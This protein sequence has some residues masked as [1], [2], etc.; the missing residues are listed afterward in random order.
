MT[1]DYR[2]RIERSAAAPGSYKFLVHLP[3]GQAAQVLGADRPPCAITDEERDRLRSGL[4]KQEEHDKLQDAVSHW[5]LDN[6]LDLL[7]HSALQNGIDPPLRVIWDVEHELRPTLAELPFEMIRGQN[8]DKPYV[9]HRGIACFTHQLPKVGIPPSSPSARTWPLRCLIIRSNPQD[10]GGRVPPGLPI[11]AKILAANPALGPGYLEVD[12]LSREGPDPAVV[13]VPTFQ[14]LVSRL[15]GASYD[16]LIYL[17]HGDLRESHGDLAPLGLLQF[18]KGDGR[19]H[20][21]VAANRFAMVLHEFPVP[22]VLLVGCLTAADQGGAAGA[23]AEKEIPRWMRGSQGVAQALV[24][25]ESGVQI[26]VGMRCR[27]DADEADEFL[28]AFFQSLLTANGNKGN[29]EAA[30]RAG[31][32]QL[33]VQPRSV[34]GYA[35]PM[36]FSTLPAEP[37]FPF[38]AEAIS[39]APVPEKHEA[40]RAVFWRAAAKLRTREAVAEIEPE[41]DNVE[42]EMLATMG[43]G[44]SVLMPA[45]CIARS[46]TTVSIAVGL[47]GRPYGGAFLAGQIVVD[48]TELGID[49]VRLAPGVQADGWRLL[50]ADGA[51]GQRRDFRMERTAG[52]H[53]LPAGPVLDI[54]LTLGIR[55]KGVYPTTIVN[56]DAPAAA[57]PVYAVGNAVIVPPA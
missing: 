3:A 28:V 36:L 47:S 46:G 15:R 41:L 33:A 5:V 53:D 37:M 44:A 23:A 14:A 32:W 10:L 48:G 19:T 17:G 21:P 9:T 20:D 2:V 4:L 31:R 45:R 57:L 49:T 38:I 7:L 40:V 34:A 30:V 27:I 11:R 54:A 51:G 55:A 18:E 39:P 56:L 16:L 6:G 24:N 8:T 50:T 42:R 12:V 1:R 52:A 29:V 43:A 13:D 25:S 26:A 35:A 22:V